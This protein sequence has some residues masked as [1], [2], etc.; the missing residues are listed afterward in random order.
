MYLF[1]VEIH[2][3]GLRSRCQSGEVLAENPAMPKLTESLGFRQQPSEDRGVLAVSLP[4][5]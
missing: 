5:V 4:L 3:S 2:A 1:R